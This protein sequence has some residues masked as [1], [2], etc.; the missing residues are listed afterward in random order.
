MTDAA[1]EQAQINTLAD[2]INVVAAHQQAAQTQ[3]QAYIAAHPDA[4]P[5]D[6][7]PLVS[8]VASLQNADTG[9]AAVLPAM[10]D[11]PAPADPIPAPPDDPSVPVVDAPVDTAPT[12]SGAATDGTTVDT[13]PPPDQ[14]A[15]F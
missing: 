4:P 13:G 5:A 3:I 2:A 15:S 10:P 8:A 1:A 14:P 12:D 11:A 9:L 7:T 6:L